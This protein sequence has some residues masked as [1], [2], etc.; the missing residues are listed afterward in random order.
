MEGVGERLDRLAGDM[1]DAADDCFAAKRLMAGV[2]LLYVTI[3][4]MAW[5]DRPERQED[6]QA[7]DFIAW[8]GRYLVLNLSKPV[9]AEVLYGARCGMLHSLMCESKG[10]RTNRVWTIA[11]YVSIRNLPEY[12]AISSLGRSHVG[13]VLYVED[14]TAAVRSAIDQFRVDVEADESKAA[15]VL[16]RLVTQFSFYEHRPQQKD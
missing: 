16:P 9:T 12:S 13:H 8:A 6:V 1:I 5:L 11:A 4:A 2:A 15:I 7:S 10:S 3:D 14:F